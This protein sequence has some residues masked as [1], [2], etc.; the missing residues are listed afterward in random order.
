MN[1]RIQVE[2]PVT[3]MITGLDLVQEMIRIAGGE[4]LS[5][6]QEDIKVTGHAI[7]CR[8][9][10][11]DPAR[12]FMPGPGTV[13]TL[14]VPQGEGVRFDTMLYEGYTV[15]PFYDSLLG[16]LIVWAET[17]DACLDR[18]GEAL[19]DLEIEASRRRSRCTRPGADATSRRRFHTRFLEGWLET[20]FAAP[21]T[22]RRLDNG[23]AIHSAATSISS[24]NAARKCR[25]R[26]SS[27]AFPWPMAS[28][29]ASIKGVTEICPAN[30]SF[31]IK[32]DP[33][34]IKPDDILREVK[35]IEG[36]AAEVRSRLSRRGSSKFRCSTTIHGPTRR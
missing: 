13:S 22:R 27:R 34:V 23:L 7:E 25:W 28:G 6:R 5:V 26:P 16:K 19:R 30:A 11:E 17:R 4:K 20:E 33:D 12:D 32:F 35:S 29:K 3:E 36:A 2:H 31:Q 8:I 10:A 9:N 24:S 14:V 1:T 21:T 18:L 15:P